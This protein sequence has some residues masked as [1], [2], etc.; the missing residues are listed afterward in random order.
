MNILK[1]ESFEDVSIDLDASAPA[2]VHHEGKA[3]DFFCDHWNDGKALM[4][5]RE[6]VKNPIVKMIITCCIYLGNGIKKKVCNCEQVS[7]DE[8]IVVTE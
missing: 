2:E 4:L 1:P 6:M 5:A 3:K 8:P 7:G